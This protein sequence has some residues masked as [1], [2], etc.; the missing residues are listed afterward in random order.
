MSRSA[1]LTNVFRAAGLVL[2][3]GVSMS[4]YSATKSYKEEVLLHD[5]KT[6]VVEHQLE[7][8]PPTFE[9]RGQKELGETLSFMLPGTDKKIVWTTS[10]DDSSPEPNGLGA[11]LLDVVNG[12]PY[13]AT[14]PSGCISYNKWKRPNPPYIFF[15][16]V[17]GEWK[18]IPLSDFPP[19]LTHSNLMSTPDLRTL[20]PYY[21]VEQVRQQ[22]EGRVIE[23]EAKT[24]YRKPIRAWLETCPVLVPIPGVPGGWET[25]GGARS[26]KSIIVPPRAGGVNKN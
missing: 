13:L 2:A 20:K 1:W 7:L 23:P 15:K 11:L 4:A 10:F 5:G 17:G 8:S 16:Y 9:G 25:P 19:E 26:I 6:L 3:L 22:M 14:S 18:R 12:V 21:T 24:I